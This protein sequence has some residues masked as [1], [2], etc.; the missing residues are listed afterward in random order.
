MT[1]KR[2]IDRLA[3]RHPEVSDGPRVIYI[4][5]PDEDPRC[6]FIIGGGSLARLNGESAVVFRARAEM[7]AG[8]GQA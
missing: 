3:A 5:G 7:A 8:H 4:S 2:R 1:M 6:A